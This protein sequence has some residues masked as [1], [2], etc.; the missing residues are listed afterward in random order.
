M[1]IWYLFSNNFSQD[2][3]DLMASYVFNILDI[4]TDIS[5]FFNLYIFN[6]YLY[7]YLK[8][9]PIY[10]YKYIHMY[11]QIIIYKYKY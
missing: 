10:K 4:A 7:L 11:I 8:I 2:T 1:D 3:L 9:Y 5:T 6:C